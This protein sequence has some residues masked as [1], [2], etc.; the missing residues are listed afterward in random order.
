EDIYAQIEALQKDLIDPEV[1][2]LEQEKPK[3]VKEEQAAYQAYIQARAAIRLKQEAATKKLQEKNLAKRQ[4]EWEIQQLKQQAE[5]LEAERRARELEEER[6]A[7]EL[8]EKAKLALLNE[9]WDML[10]AGAPWREWAEKHQI[11]AGHFI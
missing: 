3:A 8:E 4:K 11:E 5:K 1:E 9:R 6:K 10:T 2:Q 7:K